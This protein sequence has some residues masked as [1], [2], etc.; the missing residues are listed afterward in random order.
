MKKL[1]FTLIIFL[2]ISFQIKAQW[3]VQYS[4]PYL[5]NLYQCHFIDNNKGWV[6]GE[7]VFFTMNGGL[8]WY[9]TTS[10]WWPAYSVHFINNQTGFMGRSSNLY[11]TNNGGVNWEIALSLPLEF[12]IY[13]IYFDSLKG[14]VAGSHKDFN[15][16]NFLFYSND[17][18][19]TWTEV[20][21]PTDYDLNSICFRNNIDGYVVGNNGLILKTT[22]G[23]LSWIETY[24][25]S[26]NLQSIFFKSELNGWIGSYGG[27]YKTIDGGINWNFVPI[28][29][30]EFQ[31]I[32]FINNSRGFTCE[33]SN[34][35]LTM[36][37]GNNWEVVDTNDV[38]YIFFVDN[39]NGWTVGQT[40][41]I[42][43][44]T[45]GGVTFIEDEENNFT[46]PKE[47]ILQQNYPNPFNPST[48]ISWQSPISG[49]QT[50]KVYDVLG[51]EV[52]TLVD[53]Y[54]N[55]GSYEVEFKSSVGSRQPAYRTG[56]LAN[57]VYFYQLKAGDYLETKKMILLK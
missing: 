1:V 42:L 30:G 28:H 46:Q 57:G 44:T 50:L 5:V 32:T 15:D 51:N 41:K 37:G 3:Y 18:G 11:K 19:A 40:G 38:S 13:S 29:S 33:G 34:L 54:R 17:S 23:G 45:N 55:A 36:D 43:H 12:Q 2:S 26:N 35:L 21:S 24:L 8:N 4:Y 20:Q 9:P 53:E 14:I 10:F 27:I 48:K 7:R 49:W 39:L 52:A 25:G 22:D 16:G 56:R 31:S 47:F 6:V